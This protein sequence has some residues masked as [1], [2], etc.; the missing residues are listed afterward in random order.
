MKLKSSIIKDSHVRGNMFITMT[1][2][3]S[4]LVCPFVTP[5][6]LS[7]PWKLQICPR[8]QFCLF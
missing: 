4:L 3:L 7:N 5:S 8:P 6:I 1:I 2:R